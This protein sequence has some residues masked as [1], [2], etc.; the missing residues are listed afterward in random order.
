MPELR[1]AEHAFPCRD[2]LPPW[3]LMELAAAVNSADPMKQMG[4]MHDFVLGV[5]LPE[6]H[7]AFVRAMR[8]LDD[9]DTALDQLNAAIGE[10]M[11]EYQS[12]PTERPSRSPGGVVPTGRLSRVVSLSRG[13]ARADETS[14][15]DGALTGS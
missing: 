15:M 5:V 7:P 11:K 13:T 1:L 3:R 8:A 4:G 14:S 12:R 2:R 10:L 9:D 6:H